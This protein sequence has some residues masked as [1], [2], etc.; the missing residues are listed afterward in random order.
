MDTQ[1][2]HVGALEDG[3]IAGCLS[4]ESLLL[5]SFRRWKKVNVCFEH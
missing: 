1:C 3:G 2:D 5:Q 4:L